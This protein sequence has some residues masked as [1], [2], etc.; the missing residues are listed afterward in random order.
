MITKTEAK[1]RF[2]TKKPAENKRNK[3][4]TK[5]VKKAVKDYRRTFELLAA[6]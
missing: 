4:I 1:R 3:V 5:A 6:R 2:G